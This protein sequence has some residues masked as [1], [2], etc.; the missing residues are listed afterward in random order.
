MKSILHGI[1]NSK[2]WHSHFHKTDIFMKAF[3]GGNNTNDCG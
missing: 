2:M 1:L 3:N